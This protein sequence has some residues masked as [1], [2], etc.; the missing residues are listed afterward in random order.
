MEL[1]LN[2]FSLALFISAV[3]TAGVG[4][5][6]FQRR[7]VYGSYS[8]MAILVLL[9]IW[10]TSYGLENLNPSI[11]W[12][13]FWVS[14]HYPAI[15]FV[16]VAWLIFSI[17]YTLQQKTP[18]KSFF[19]LGIIPV[20]TI[21]IAWT[22]DLHGLLWQSRQ[23]INISG[24]MI[25]KSEHGPY[26]AIHAIYSYGVIFAG[27][28]FLIRHALKTGK[29]YQTQ[30]IIILI[31]VIFFITG[32]GLYLLKLLPFEG[33]D[34]TPFSFTISSLI[35][36]YGLFRHH[37]LDLMP[38]ANEIILQNI[39]DGVLVLDSQKRIAF[40]NSSFEKMTG[41]LP[42]TSVGS[43]I[44]DVLFNWP[45]I[46]NE[47]QIVRQIETKVNTGDTER[48][49]QIQTNPIWHRDTLQGCIYVIHDITERASQ[50]EKMR[51]FIESRE[52]VSEDY[53]FM[54]L[55]KTNSI[56]LDVNS[57]FTLAT[58]YTLEE[59]IGKSILTLNFV[60][61]ET[62]AL[63]NRL[64]LTSPGIYDMSITIQAKNRQ[65]QDWNISITSI[66]LNETG[67]RIW[68]AQPARFN[69]VTRPL[70]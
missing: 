2:T 9:T 5:A 24:M 32:N 52:K 66:N 50:E 28:F 61:V 6:I 57:S 38:I 18:I 53:I 22:N 56:F 23:I 8:M 33:L 45:D 67:F 49:L 17:Q 68:V 25:M 27:I 42:D 16:P 46:F 34:I 35:L 20:F 11:T 51:L 41:L 63:L 37:L 4:F 48:Y 21:L 10:S 59:V 54:A 62:R 70:R 7:K 36:S 12:H 31:S 65:E 39:G 13:K 44:H 26:F 47:M 43:P 60:S 58:G 15:A 55:D 30:A 29:S 3:V 19:L 64:L 69:V 14:I 1:S 40:I